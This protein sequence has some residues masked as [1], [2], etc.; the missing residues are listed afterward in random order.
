MLRCDI[1]FLFCFCFNNIN[2]KCDT[3]PVTVCG[4][5]LIYVTSVFVNIKTVTPRTQL[6]QFG[7]LSDI[8]RIKFIY[9]ILNINLNQTSSVKS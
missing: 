6:C 7:F 2:V 9:S 4:I 3:A 1:L 5:F 8:W